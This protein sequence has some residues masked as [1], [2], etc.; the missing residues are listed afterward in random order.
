MSSLHGMRS[1][2][3]FGGDY[4]IG[5]APAISASPALNHSKSPAYAQAGNAPIP[6]ATRTPLVSSTPPA[7]HSKHRSSSH[8]SSL[9]FLVEVTE[10]ALDDTDNAI[11]FDEVEVADLDS[12]IGFVKERL[13]QAEI[14]IVQLTFI[15][16]W[17]AHARYVV[18]LTDGDNYWMKVKE[19]L[20]RNYRYARTTISPPEDGFMVWI[21]WQ[22]EVGSENE[23]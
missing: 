15:Q 22:C 14:A 17:G 1:E 4:D 3:K 13:I 8:S 5:R 10:G 19:S 18:N 20:K 9:K 16:N 2:P 12:M 7:S 21:L 11:T 6:V 23:D